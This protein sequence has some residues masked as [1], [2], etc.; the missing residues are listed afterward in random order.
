MGKNIKKNIRIY[1]Y[2]DQFAVKQKLTQHCKSTILQLK[3]IFKI[4]GKY[5]RGILVFFWSTVMYISIEGI[6]MWDPLFCA[7]SVGDL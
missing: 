7:S 4:K 2:L 1:I 6:R 5:H 3:M